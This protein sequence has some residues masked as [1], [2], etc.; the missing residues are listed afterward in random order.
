MR[1]RRPSLCRFIRSSINKIFRGFFSSNPQNLPRESPER[2]YGAPAN[3]RLPNQNEEQSNIPETGAVGQQNNTNNTLTWQPGY[4]LKSGEFIIERELGRG[5]FGIT[6]LAQDKN[7]SRFVL[8]TIINQVEEQSREKWAEFWE[9]LANEAVKLAQC[10]GRNPHIVKLYKII[11]EREFPCIVMEYIEGLTLDSIVEARG[12]LEEKQALEYITQIG[13]ALTEI[14]RQGLLHRD[15]KPLNIIVRQDGSGAV[16]IDFGIARKFASGVTKTYLPAVSPGFAPIEQYRWRSI[17]DTYTDVYGLAATLYF[18]L[19]G[20]KP[21]TAERRFNGIPLTPPNQ[22]NSKISQRVN[23]AIMQ[24][25]QLKG[26]ERPRSIEAFL[27]ELLGDSGK[28]ATVI[29][30]DRSSSNHSRALEY[31]EGPVGIDSSFYIERPEVDP[32]CYQAILKPGALIRI[33]APK[34]MGKTSLINRILNVAD[35]ELDCRTVQLNLLETN[36]EVLSSLK[37][38]LQWFCASTARALKLPHQLNELWDDD[39]LTSTSNCTNYFEDYLLT[40]IDCPLVLSLD[41]VD[42]IFPYEKIAPDF[43]ALLRFWHEKGKNHAVWQQLRLVVAHSTEVYLK[44]KTTQ[45]PFNVGIPVELPELTPGQVQELASRHQLV[46][47]DTQVRALMKLVGGHPH[48]LRRAMYSIAREKVTLEDLLSNTATS[49]GIYKDHLRRF[50]WS[51]KQDPDLASVF[52]KVVTTKVG[53]EL[54]SSQKLRLA[55][56]GLIKVIGNLAV[57]RCNLYRQYFSH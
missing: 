50:D 25:M 32:L 30:N 29:L 28:V 45:S 4:Q 53:V 13:T 43:F 49:E 44:L 33:K 36:E 17:Q 7:G 55:R 41:E 40:Q 1:E 6:Y 38:F 10:G 39:F 20:Q 47:D 2:I 26:R 54:D 22:I 19:T 48:L 11:R 23:W 14:H 52:K 16:L 46:W 24:G 56:M 8:K 51:L 3:R 31:P 5:G 35:R 21:V 27:G 37:N 12:K 9:N 34:L 15:V 57:P 18:A 42:R